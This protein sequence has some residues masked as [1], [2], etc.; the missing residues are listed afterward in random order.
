MTDVRLSTKQASWARC[1]KGA[2]SRKFGARVGMRRRNSQIYKMLQSGDP[3]V[4]RAG[5]LASQL[6]SLGIV[7]FSKR[8]STQEMSFPHQSRRISD[9]SLQKVFFPDFSTSL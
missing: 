4:K 6:R 7:L 8:Q 1:A 5:H 3:C 2:W 9:S